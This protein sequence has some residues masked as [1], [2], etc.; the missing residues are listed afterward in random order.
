MDRWT[1]RNEESGNFL[2]TGDFK[3]KQDLINY[4]GH[5]EDILERILENAT[6]R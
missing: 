6:N 1:V 4:I 5:L 2:L 3:D